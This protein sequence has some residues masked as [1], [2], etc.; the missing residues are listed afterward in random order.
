MKY[1]L[2]ILI[3]LTGCAG[4]HFDSETETM[5]TN[6]PVIQT[7]TGAG[8]QFLTTQSLA[9]ASVQTPPLPTVQS[10]SALDALAPPPGAISTQAPPNVIGWAS[11]GPYVP[12]VPCDCQGD[13]A[14]LI[15]HSDAAIGP[16]T[17]ALTFL[18][19]V[20]P[21]DTTIVDRA[22]FDR[23]GSSGFWRREVEIFP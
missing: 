8:W 2:P 22:M 5:L 14:V 17:T 4:K 15:Q 18:P 13:Y 10:S 21:M 11:F 6:A 3:L 1:L 9:V 12:P 16:W 20:I 19:F 7:N 23:S